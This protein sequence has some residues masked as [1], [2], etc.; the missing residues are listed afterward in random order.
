[1]S[2]EIR[3]I[4]SGHLRQVGET[5][6]KWMKLGTAYWA[7]VIQ[8][9]LCLV[10]LRRSLQLFP[11]L[12]RTLS[13]TPFAREEH[14]GSESLGNSLEAIAIGRSKAEVL[15]LVWSIKSLHLLTCLFKPIHKKIFTNHCKGQ[16]VHVTECNEFQISVLCLSCLLSYFLN[17]E[18]LRN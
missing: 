2:W 10:L 5:K 16:L 9:A 15:T 12:V 18:K 1:M 14:W 6:E 4:I 13:V 7:P 17:K 11:E 8:Q 3:M